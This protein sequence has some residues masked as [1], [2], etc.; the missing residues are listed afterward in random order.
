MELNYKEVNG[1]VIT[2]TTG[3]NASIKT[4]G[5]TIITSDVTEIVGIY[6]GMFTFKT[7]NSVYAVTGTIITESKEVD[8]QT[9]YNKIITILTSSGTTLDITGPIASLKNR[10]QNRSFNICE[11]YFKAVI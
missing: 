11:D 7:K 8:L 9:T 5:E 6:N 1:I 2:C 4:N 3:Y 10:E